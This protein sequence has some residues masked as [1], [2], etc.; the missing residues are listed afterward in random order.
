MTR[1]FTAF[2]TLF[3]FVVPMTA[4][5]ANDWYRAESEHFIL[6][7]KDSEADTLEFVQD[8]ERL[9]EVIALFTGVDLEAAD[10]PPSS[11]LTVFRY[12]TQADMSALAADRRDS[13]IGGFYIP[14]AEGSVAFVPRQRNRSYGRSQR[15]DNQT[16][17]LQL[18]PR[19]V[20][21]H[22]YVH[23]FMFQHADAPY[24]LWYSEGF[25]E[26]FGNLEFGEDYFII[27]ELPPSRSASLA[28]VSI[29]LEATL[30]PKPGRDRYYT[31]RTYGHGWLFAH[32]LN[33]NPERRG[34][35]TTYM[36]AIAAGA[37][38]MDAAEQ[39]FGDLDAFEAELE[40]FRTGASRPLRVPYAVNPNPEVDIRRLTEAEEARMDLMIESKAGVTEEEAQSLVGQARRLLERYPNDE[41]VLLAAI[42]AE[43]DA[44][45]YDEAEALAERALAINPESVDAAMYFANVALRRSFEDPAQMEVARARFAAAN[46]ME[47]D[48][49][50]PLYGYYLTHLHD[51]D[52]AL[53]E[54]AKA[55]LGAAFSYGRHDRGVRQALVH[56]LLL[57]GRTDEAR[58]VGAQFTDGRGRLQCLVRKQFDEFEEGNREPLLETI[59]PD[60]PGEYL[61]DDAREARREEFEAKVEAYGCTDGGEDDA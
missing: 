58:I 25:A 15:R 16:R 42:E 57:E 52:D 5:N 31:D 26:L 54:N 20:L 24:P 59:R 60:H 41:A 37:S 11:K 22:E 39:A 44:R 48:H 28:R 32:H 56:M 55:A 30:D 45:N 2:I 40:E 38:R 50:F 47:N 61:D 46:R 36:N 12:G 43:F 34:Q 8:L 1:F 9:N 14:R 51:G 4:A 7:S 33:I 6:Y 10:L 49:P 29:D 21:F 3:A 19:H 17:D 13:G 27:G 23:H 53:T 18:D 35:M